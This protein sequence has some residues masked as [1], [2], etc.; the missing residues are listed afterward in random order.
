M[1]KFRA[2]EY[3]VAAAQEG[4]FSGA[5]RRLEVSIPAIAKM[6]TAL[7]RSLGASLFDRAPQ[8]LTLTADGVRY[9]ESCRPLLE[10]LGEADEAISAGAAR[11]RGT[12]V[13]G[14]PPFVLQNCLVGAIPRFHARYPDVQLDFRIV[15]RLTDAEAA[16]VEVFVLFGWHEVQD[17][18]Q[19]RIAETRYHVYAAPSYWAAHGVPQHP[20][21]LAGHN[22]LCF[23]NPEGTL[24]D[25]WEFERGGEVQ[26]VA[27]SG[28]LSSSHRDFV[29][30]AALAGEGVLRVSGLATWQHVQS[31][32]LVAVLQD[33]DV[34]HGPPVTVLYRPSQRRTPR[35]RVF[36][37]FVTDLFRELE[38]QREGSVAAHAAERP[39]WQ[40]KRYGKASSIQRGPGRH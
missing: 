39:E 20:R 6:I 34:R 10:Q 26:S 38:T 15:S 29:V 33:W 22:C 37:D 17:M 28:W 16:T 7:E 35:V 11:P 9:L 13:V 14:S 31:G 19:K 8:G 27:V 32:R 3:F 23:R 5:S 24:L 2:L 21:E 12:L 4:S 25:L 1:D 40:G 18:V 30:D 36:V